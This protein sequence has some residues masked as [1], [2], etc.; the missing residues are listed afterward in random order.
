MM[1]SLLHIA[2][3]CEGILSCV[4]MLEDKQVNR[5]CH[6]SDFLE[7][8]HCHLVKL[9]PWCSYMANP[10]NKTFKTMQETYC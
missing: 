2:F 3:F 8:G 1:S 10:C 7:L 9:H 5:S 4:A 6:I